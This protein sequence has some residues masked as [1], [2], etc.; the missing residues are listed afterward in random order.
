MRWDLCAHSA[1]SLFRG[2]LRGDSRGVRPSFHR[3][4]LQD[5]CFQTCFVNRQESPIKSAPQW[6]QEQ[7]QKERSFLSPY[8]TAI[9]CQLKVR[10]FID[11]DWLGPYFYFTSPAFTI[12][13]KG[14]QIKWKQTEPAGEALGMNNTLFTLMKV[15]RNRR[16]RRLCYRCTRGLEP[17]GIIA[18]LCSVWTFPK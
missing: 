7:W 12:H 9:S 3:P 15:L 17:E 16:A 14:A 6:T 11:F 18:A 4:R 13:C 10:P 8:F 1:C 5:M 2:L